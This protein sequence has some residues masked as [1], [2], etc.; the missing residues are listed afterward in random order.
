[1]ESSEGPIRGFQGVCMIWGLSVL[2]MPGTKQV[3]LSFFAEPSSPAYLT[4]SFL[5]ALQRPPNQ[6]FI[7]ALQCG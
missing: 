4:L 6:V 5:T 7:G 2:C 1:M 3:V